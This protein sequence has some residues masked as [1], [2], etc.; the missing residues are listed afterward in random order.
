[1]VLNLLWPCGSFSI[2]QKIGRFF[3]KLTQSATWQRIIKIYVAILDW[4]LSLW[5]NWI[6]EPDPIVIILTV[7]IY[8]E[9]S[10]FQQLYLWS[11]FSPWNLN[12]SSPKTTDQ[13]GCRC[14]RREFVD[15]ALAFSLLKPW[16]DPANY[17]SEAALTFLST[18]YLSTISEETSVIIQLSFPSRSF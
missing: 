4:Q 8:V 3:L 13:I 10:K 2:H 7:L 17:P 14:V 5:E 1:M 9:W 16:K 15:A 6:Y 11:K 18:P 12:I